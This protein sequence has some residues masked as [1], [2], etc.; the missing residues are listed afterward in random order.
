M[1]VEE[2]EGRPVRLTILRQLEEQDI[3]V[4]AGTG[5]R[6]KTGGLKGEQGDKGTVPLERLLHGLGVDSWRCFSFV[7]EGKEQDE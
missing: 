4:R 5:E 6:E 7:K 1:A 3:T 2:A